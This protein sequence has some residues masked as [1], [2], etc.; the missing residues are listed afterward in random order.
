MC[1]KI[2]DCCLPKG[3]KDMLKYVQ[4]HLKRHPRGGPKKRSKVFSIMSKSAI[5][6]KRAKSIALQLS[7]KL[8]SR[9]LENGLRSRIYCRCCRKCFNGNR[10]FYNHYLTSHG[11]TSVKVAK[12]VSLKKNTSDVD[13]SDEESR[14]V[15][16]EG[17]LVSADTLPKSEVW[18]VTYNWHNQL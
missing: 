9:C 4:F 15:I 12:N 3:N 10:Q 14:L 13:L 17:N 5:V 18:N 8:V 1:V 11:S 7:R 6:V 2:E 16:D